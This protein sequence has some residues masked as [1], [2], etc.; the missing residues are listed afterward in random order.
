MSAFEECLSATTTREAPWY[1]V[2]ADDKENARL[3]V[4][5]IILDTLNGLE[6]TY[7]EVG[8][9]RQQ[10]LQSIRERLIGGDLD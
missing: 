7:P 10:E 6:M 8:A 1:V 2:P 9:Q 5:Q 4:S 3:I